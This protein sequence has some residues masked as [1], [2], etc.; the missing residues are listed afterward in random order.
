M[1]TLPAVVLPSLLPAFLLAG[2]NF[3]LSLGAGDLEAA[4]DL[5][6]A[7]EGSDPPGDTPDDGLPET[8]VALDGNLYAIHP[9]SMQVVEPAG[10][11]ALFGDVLDRDVLVYVESESA[12][13]LQLDVALAS[14]EGR[15]DRCE[16]VRRFPAGDWTQNPV[17]DVGPGELAA[18]FGGHAAAFRSLVLSGVFDA[19][20]GEWTDGTLDAQLDTRELAP[21]LSGQGDLCALVESLG[22]ACEPC[23]DGAPFCF[24]L[25]IA[26]IAGERVDAPFDPGLDGSACAH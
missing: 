22:G 5:P 23:D 25:R 26:G 2:C 8:E 20:G 6:D 7:A 9:A 24:A 15:Q 14:P 17:F 18:S 4:G 13:A 3:G 21:A 16:A 11:D 10:L 19:S 1:R 12:A